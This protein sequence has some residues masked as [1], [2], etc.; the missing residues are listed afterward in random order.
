MRF[1]TVNLNLILF[2][3]KKILNESC[4]LFF[5]LVIEYKHLCLGLIVKGE[6]AEEELVVG[7]GGGVE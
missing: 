6:L 2:T 1:N 7:L 3:I 4:G 5:E